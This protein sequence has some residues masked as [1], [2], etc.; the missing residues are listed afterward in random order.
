MDKSLE[1]I[2]AIKNSLRPVV[3]WIPME[4]IE[5]LVEINQMFKQ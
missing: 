1:T 5:L 2:T 3:N 4:E